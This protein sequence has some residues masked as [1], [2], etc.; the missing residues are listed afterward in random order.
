MSAT[1]RKIGMPGYPAGLSNQKMALELA[2]GVAYLTGRT[3]EL[4]NLPR[5]ENRGGP[6]IQQR[7][8]DLFEVPIPYQLTFGAEATEGWP[9]WRWP[10]V[11][12]T[13]L[14]APGVGCDDTRFRAF[15]NRRPHA[16]ELA[17]L[18][19]ARS[20]ARVRIE[21]DCLLGFYSYVFLLPPGEEQALASLMSKVRP[22]PQYQQLAD[23]LVSGVGSFDAL[24][25][26]LGDFTKWDAAYRTRLVSAEEIVENLE[27]RIERAG[28]LLLLTDTPSHSLAHEI[29]ESY[30]NAITLDRWLADRP[31][32]LKAFGRP[33]TGA[34]EGLVGQL[35][36]ANSGKFAGTM[37]STFSALIH[38]EKA[39]RDGDATFLFAYNQFPEVFELE[40]CAMVEESGPH[41]FS[42]NRLRRK[43]TFDS[44]YFSWFR[45]WPEA[46]PATS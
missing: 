44:E 2:V 27:T 25:L 45:E 5:V 11:P 43:A 31:G 33:L 3:L 7:V 34:E 38:R 6:A 17:Q 23:E 13:V 42:W 20:P 28:L 30:P 10:S 22:K 46:L 16:V 26:R 24:H 39:R 1:M 15:A 40:R 29:C 9:V 12:R 8:T 18:S 4:Q 41:R 21:T 19:D 14:V 35:V 37:S 36:A 32:A